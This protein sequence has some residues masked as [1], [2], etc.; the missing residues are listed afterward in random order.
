[1]ANVSIIR[2]ADN[3]ITLRH[4]RLV[5][6]VSPELKTKEEFADAVRWA[7]VSIGIPTDTHGKTLMQVIND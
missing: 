5:I 3:T 2:N 4:G 7:A 6:H 1:M